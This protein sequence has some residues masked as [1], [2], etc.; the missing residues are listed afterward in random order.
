MTQKK[1]ITIYHSPDADDA[2]MFYGLTSGAVEN[3]AYTF[4]HDLADIET[5]NQ[6]TIRGELD[7]TAVSVHAYAYLKN[8]YAI[9]TCGASMG[10]KD[11]GPRIVAREKFDIMDGTKRTIAIP[12]EKTSAALSLQ[13]YL[14][15]KGIE[16]ELVNMD[17]DK[18]GDAVTAGDVDCGIIIH[19]GQI[20]H[21]KDGLCLVLDLGK[22][23][24][25]E[26]GLPL[27][28]GVN[29]VRKS[30]GED[31][32]I[33]S[34]LALKQ[35]ISYSLNN[36]EKALEYALTYGRGIS[37]E[38][39][40]TFVGMYVNELTLDM[41]KEGIESIKLFLSKGVEYGFIPSEIEIEFVDPEN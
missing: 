15:E 34:A 26:T 11:Y 9:L 16:A 2:F 32:I 1:E 19:E 8:Q 40:D 33:A 3:D 14:H 35:S 4:T 41:G 13:I 38:E 25:D 5:L 39:A 27:P 29:V 28:L 21:D 30:L 22:W 24:W 31:A 7:V 20:T 10:G 23:W 18:V 36:R 17:F 12:G 37:T 6:R